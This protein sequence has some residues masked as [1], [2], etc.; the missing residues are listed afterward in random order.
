FDAAAREFGWRGRDP[1]P[2]SM[3]KGDWLIGWGCAATM[4]PTQMGP[5]AA[6][7]TLD[8]NGSA[9][10]QTAAHDIGNRASTV[11]AMTAARRPGLPL[12]RIAVEFGDSDLPP[13]TV[14]GGSNT[15]ASVCN[16][17]AKACEDIRSRIA[18]AAVAAPEAAFNGKD[19][20]SL[21]LKDG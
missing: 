18:A 19:P 14:A 11:I 13:A 8:A 9:R 6:R 2:G 15:T 17:V 12:D 1:K 20:D 7:V 21:T 16:T 10:V 4:Y 3:R 5:A